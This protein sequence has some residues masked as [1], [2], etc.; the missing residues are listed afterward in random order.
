MNLL[1]RKLRVGVPFVL[2]LTM[3]CKNEDSMV[4]P[5]KDDGFVMLHHFLLTE[6]TY[7]SISI[8]AS[9]VGVSAQTIGQIKIVIPGKGNDFWFSLKEFDLDSEKYSISPEV[10]VK[11]DFSKGPVVYSIVLKKAPNKVVAYYTVLIQ[12]AEQ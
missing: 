7:S 11:Q 6:A 10:G 9:K 4:N 5:A 2:L 8:N 3:S 1:F 12:Y